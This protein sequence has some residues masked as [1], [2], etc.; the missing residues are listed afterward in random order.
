MSTVSVNF[1]MDSEVK[2]KME[3]ACSAMGIS[4]TAA[5][6]MFAKKVGNERRIPF[7]LADD[8][9]YSES[10]IKHL[11]SIIE[12]VKNGTEKLEAHDLIEVD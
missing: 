12:R 3:S 7:E 4:M 5:F 1:R 11:L 8:P 9:F 2:K 6:N 10:N